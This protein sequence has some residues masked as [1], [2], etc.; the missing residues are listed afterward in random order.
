M[1]KSKIFDL[2]KEKSKNQRIYIIDYFFLIQSLKTK[3]NSK[4][5]EETNNSYEIVTKLIN[6]Y[7]YE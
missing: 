1:F 4:S 5:R 6:V 3:I 2:S 7:G